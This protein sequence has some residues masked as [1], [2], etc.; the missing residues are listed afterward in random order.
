MKFAVLD[1]AGFLA[2]APP[3]DEVGAR[4]RAGQAAMAARDFAT[5]SKE[6]SAVLSVDPQNQAA[7]FHLGVI[8]LVSGDAAAGLRHFSALPEDP[9]ALIGRLDCELRLGRSDEARA[10]ATRLEPVVQGDSAAN[11]HVGMLLAKAGLHVEAIPFLRGGTG[12][13]AAGLL[14]AAEEKTGNLPAAVEAFAE[15]VR[16]EP[17]NED[18]RID[19]AAV[20]LSSG[21]FERSIAAFRE[22]AAKFPKSARSQ[23]GL[24]SAL[25]LAGRHEEAARAL[26]GAVRLD[27]SPRAFELLGQAYEAAGELQS[28]VAAEFRKYLATDPRDATAYSHYAAILHT[29]G[30]DPS[31]ARRYLERAL[32]LDA[33]LAPAHLQLGIIEQAQGNTDAA[34]RCFQRAAQLDPKNAAVHYRLGTLYQKLGDREKARLELEQFRRL[35]A[36]TAAP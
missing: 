35:K 11:T 22:A 19:H 13:V 16:L 14:G 7:H 21:E 32:Q 31:E 15:A 23:L 36:I 6:F 29:S 33:N 27:P 25:Y 17:E 1:L 24:G 4:L 3:A 20:L 2:A 26:L 5:A 18:Y 10:T 28:Q 30:A 12:A 8:A 34:L 9:R